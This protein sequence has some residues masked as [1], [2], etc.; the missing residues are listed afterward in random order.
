MKPPK[1]FFTWVQN[2]KW[3][4][5]QE[6]NL[7]P[8]AIIYSD[9]A[10]QCYCRTSMKGPSHTWNSIHL[11]NESH[12]GIGSLIAGVHWRPTTS[13][14]SLHQLDFYESEKQGWSSFHSYIGCQTSWSSLTVHHNVRKRASLPLH[15]LQLLSSIA[16]ARQ[17]ERSILVL[18]IC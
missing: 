18:Q 2:L 13:T 3:G 7:V 8:A 1:W 15:L 16:V 4:F 10:G 9:K 5:D 17:T 12:K 14:Q 11:E 6:K